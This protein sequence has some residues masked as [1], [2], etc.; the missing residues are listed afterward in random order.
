MLRLLIFLALLAAV[1]YAVFWL[2]E[3]RA[4]NGGSGGKAVPRGPVGPDDDED[5]LRELERKRRH[6][7]GEGP[8]P[9]T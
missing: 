6:Q 5:F 3:R 9:T 8:S 1:V 4:Q 7:K 2:I